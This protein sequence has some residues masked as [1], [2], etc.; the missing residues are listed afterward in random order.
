MPCLHAWLQ[1]HLGVALALRVP[2]FF[3]VTKVDICP[4]HIL[5]HTVAVS[6]ARPGTRAVHAMKH[7][8]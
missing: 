8:L 6:Q 7:G 5:K 3:V 2:V 4:D 1:E